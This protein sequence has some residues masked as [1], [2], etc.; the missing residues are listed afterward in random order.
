MI[1][2]LIQTKFDTNIN[3]DELLKT[4]W[5]HKRIFLKNFNHIAIIKPNGAFTNNYCTCHY[6]LA[7]INSQHGMSKKIH[8]LEIMIELLTY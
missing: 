4:I 2:L 6:G 7:L 1:C 8:K 5:E 3:D